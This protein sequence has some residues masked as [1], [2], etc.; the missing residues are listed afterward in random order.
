MFYLS[1][2]KKLSYVLMLLSAS[3][4]CSMICVFY[5]E[6]GAKIALGTVTKFIPGKVKIEKVHGSLAQGVLL[7]AVSYKNRTVNAEIEHASVKLSIKDLICLKLHLKNITANNINLKFVHIDPI[8]HTLQHNIALWPNRQKSWYTKLQIDNL[9]LSTI[10]VQRTANPNIAHIAKATLITNDGSN[11]PQTITAQINSDLFTLKARGALSDVINLEW[12]FV[13]HNLKPI[14]A[15]FSGAINGFGKIIGQQS[16]PEIFINLKSDHLAFGQYSL[17]NSKAQLYYDLNLAT[18]NIS[19]KMH[20]TAQNFNSVGGYKIDDLSLKSDLELNNTELRFLNLEVAPF[21][22]YAKDDDGS[23]IP[24]NHI[25]LNVTP[26]KNDLKAKLK[27]EFAHNSHLTANIVFPRFKHFHQNLSKQKIKGDLSVNSENLA[28]LTFFNPNIKN[29]Q[30]SLKIDYRLLGTVAAPVLNGRF[31]IDRFSF[32]LPEF[33][34][35]PQAGNLKII[36]HDNAVTYRAQFSSGNGEI[37]MHGAADLKDA[38]PLLLTINGKNFLASDTKTLQLI[39]SPA[40]ELK[41]QEQNA[42]LTGSILVNKARILPD[43]YTGVITLPKEVEIVS[44]KKNSPAWQLATKANL[45]ISTGDDVR[46]DALGLRGTLHGNLHMVVTNDDLNLVNGV[47]Q[48]RDG[49]YTVY[50]QVLDLTKDSNLNYVNASIIN[51]N[52]SIDAIRE[53]PASTLSASWYNQNQ[54]LVVGMHIRGNAELP[55]IR[56]FAKP[57]ILSDSDTISYL[58]LGQASGEASV[59]NLQLLLKAANMLN[60]GGVSRQFTNLTEQIQKSL[61]LNQLG[62]EAQSSIKTKSSLTPINSP[63]PKTTSGVQSTT[64]NTALV[65]GKYLSPQL[66]LSYGFRLIDQV[67][68]LKI[69]YILN[70]FWTLQS[71]ASTLDKGLDL[72]YRI[73]KD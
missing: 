44:T 43:N 14:W 56:L 47:L 7:N 59:D 30:G 6:L 27:C 13:T 9:D 65:L 69:S 67:S 3:L 54:N 73:E 17:G 23:K 34:I 32:Y 11:G 60:F 39:V 57:N 68:V 42:T 21:T 38:A 15:D 41:W 25:T 1:E 64:S 52:L 61:G 26:D 29:P 58:I 16:R 5:T 72:L 55:K 2:M 37:K 46:I 24:I 40:L 70:K 71:E 51:P 48:I 62:L 12:Q 33:N 28:F 66:Y 63:D 31:D 50:S 35:N 45:Y 49:S 20:V 36:H 22:V 18:K 53:F 8:K 4:V 19:G 10:S